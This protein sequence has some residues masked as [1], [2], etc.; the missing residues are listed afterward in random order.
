MRGIV[1]LVLLAAALPAVA[2]GDPMATLYLES[3]APCHTIGGGEL[4]GPDLKP[5]TTWPVPDLRAAV[6]RMQ[7]NSGP[8][9]AQQIDGL[10]AL[11]KDADVS[12]RLERAGQQGGA[13]AE[14]AAQPVAAQADPAAELYLGTCAPCHT[15]GG[16]DL[17]GPDL[18][19]S[20][21]WPEPDLRAAV[22]R[23][24]KNAGPMTAEQI[25]AL[26][27]LLKDPDVPGRLQRA[28]Q[29][30]AA[31]PAELAAEPP[32][33][34][35]GRALFHGDLAF[36]NGGL[37]CGSCHRA[38]NRGGTLATDLTDAHERLGRSALISAAVKPGF[39]LMRAAYEE[40]SV[41]REEAVDVAAYLENVAV[42]RQTGRD[43]ASIG[44]MGTLA[45]AVAMGALVL[46]YRRRNRGVRRRLVARAMRQ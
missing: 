23:M 6:E 46:V 2:Q 9:T 7:E 3:C 22:D 32:S 11:L 20:T 31:A 15:I 17:S 36:R 40:H 19:P 12:G 10:V 8:L 42:G 18:K 33:P 24:Q 44:G 43:A 16:G 13:P 14:P 39:P 30:Q 5:S 1:M 35:R 27:V 21:T 34:R 38:G 45:A 4:S 26:V 25:D 41:T 28:E 37:P 29:Q